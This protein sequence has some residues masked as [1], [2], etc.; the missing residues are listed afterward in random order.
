MK[1]EI[2]LHGELARFGGPFLMEVETAAE[3]VRALFQ[4]R[5]FRAAI[6]EGEYRMVAGDRDL[7]E[8]TLGF[9]LGRA[10]RLDIFPVATGAKQGGV[11]KVI[12]GIV[13]AI[14]AVY[15]GGA[16]AAAAGAAA[17]SGAAAGGAA[18]GGAAAASAAAAGTATA[19]WAG[20]TAFT[21]AGSAITYGNIAMFGVSMV[22]GGISQMLSSSVGVDTGGFESADQ[23]ASY[24]FNGPVNT[25]EQGGPVP[26]IFGRA[27]VGSK[28]ISAGLT[29]E[30]I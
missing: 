25:T 11:G 21:I 14:A 23:R 1:R 3:A 6:S 4:V 9:R 18:A 30:R 29:A 22:L 28:V 2:V 26:L 27:I 12:A 10:A 13:I 5:G 8:E 20:T 7:S 19:T 17:G 24:L 16:A 15:T